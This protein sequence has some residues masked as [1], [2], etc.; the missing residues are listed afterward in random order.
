MHHYPQHYRITQS[1]IL[2]MHVSQH[3]ATCCHPPRCYPL[4]MLSYSNERYYLKTSLKSFFG[5]E[6]VGYLR[7]ASN[8][9][10]NFKLTDIR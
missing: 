4:L 7:M 1:A 6:T 3:N 10:S 5:I 2:Y 8:L 9:L